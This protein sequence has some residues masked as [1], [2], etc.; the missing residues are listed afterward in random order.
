M[1][2]AQGDF[3]YLSP[4]VE[5]PGSEYTQHALRESVE[6]LTADRMAEQ[7]QLL[8]A[9]LAAAPRERRPYVARY[10]VSQFVY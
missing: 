5:M 4:L 2:L 3:V 10:D 1:R 9:S 8:R 6:P 7:E